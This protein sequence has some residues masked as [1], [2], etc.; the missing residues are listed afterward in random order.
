M[1]GKKNKDQDKP[2]PKRLSRKE[3]LRRTANASK[4]GKKGAKTNARKYKGVINVAGGTKGGTIRALR[5][6][7]AMS[8]AMKASWD[9]LTPKERAARLA[10][11]QKAKHKKDT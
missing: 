11:M 4:G 8:K 10:P 5:H 7:G 3:R 9:R 1:D 2:K 6:P